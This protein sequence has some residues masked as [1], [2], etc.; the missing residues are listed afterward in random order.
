MAPF[1]QEFLTSGILTAF[2]ADHTADMVNNPSKYFEYH[3]ENGYAY[4]DKYL[5]TTATQQSASPAASR[6]S[7][8]SVSVP[9]HGVPRS[10]RTT[11]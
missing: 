2:A 7:R 4:I 6:A 11:T 8:S 10:S 9:A 3:F 5:G 1:G